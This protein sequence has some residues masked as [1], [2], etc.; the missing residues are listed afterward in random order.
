MNKKTQ[1]RMEEL[2]WSV[3][4]TTMTVHDVPFKKNPLEVIPTIEEMDQLRDNFDSWMERQG[5]LCQR[6]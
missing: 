3:I 5:D 4:R 2:G 6:S 1:T